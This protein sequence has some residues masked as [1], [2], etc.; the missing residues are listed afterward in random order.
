[1]LNVSKFTLPRV[2]LTLVLG[3]APLAIAPLASRAQTPLPPGVENIPAAAPVEDQAFTTV[4]AYNPQG[5][6][7]NPLGQRSFV[8]VSEVDGDSVFLYESFSTPVSSPTDAARQADIVIARTLTVY[9]TPLAEAR[10]LLVNE[11]T[12][13]AELLGIDPADASGDNG[14]GP[15]NDTLACQEVSDGAVAG[16]PQP[17]TP[18]APSPEM[19]AAPPAEAAT[20][21]A[22]LPNGNYRVASADYPFRVVS[23][24]ELLESGGALFTFRKFGDSVTGNFGYIDSEIG[25]CV[26]GTVAGNTITGQAYTD[27]SGSTTDGKTYLGPGS[28][29]A[30]GEESVPDRYD[31]SVLDLGMFSRINAGT[32]LPPESCE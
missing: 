21:L 23:E 10:Q 7:P 24:E 6:V 5:G 29:L 4:C 11:P 13:Y 28:F 30:L 27:D 8:T 31:D 15:V 18:P 22:D 26:A 3:T 2:W 1:M 25:A 32:V 19:P 20:T 16:V 14:F 9:N 17:G 12:Y